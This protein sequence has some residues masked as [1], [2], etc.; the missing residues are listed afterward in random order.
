[1]WVIFRQC[2]CRDMGKTPLSFSSSSSLL[3]IALVRPHRMT[4]QSR[5]GM[6]ALENSSSSEEEDRAD[7]LGRSFQVPRPKSRSN[8]SIAVSTRVRIVASSMTHHLTPSTFA[9][10]RINRAST[11]TSTT[12]HP[13]VNCMAAPQPQRRPASVITAIT[14]RITHRRRTFQ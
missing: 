12:N 2:Q 11:M 4:M 7:L 3:T 1:M 8:G 14:T 5:A 10:S 9:Y 6:R 13:A